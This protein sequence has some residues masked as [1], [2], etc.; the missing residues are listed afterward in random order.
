MLTQN[1]KDILGAMVDLSYLQGQDRV[2]AG[3]S[4]ETAREFIATFKS[5]M[6]QML[7]IKIDGLERTL[8]RLQTELTALQT[9]QQLLV[10]NNPEL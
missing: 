5:Q 6:L 2:N 9:L 4:D 10:E 3:A 7:P 1:E 8:E